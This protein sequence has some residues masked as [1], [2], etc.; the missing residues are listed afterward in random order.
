MT[1]QES[2]MLED[3]VRKVEETELTEKDPEAEQLLQEGLG[4]DPDAIYKLAQTVL[5][6][7]LALNQARTQIQQMQ[8]TQQQAQPARATSFLGG[9]LGH[10]DPAPPAPQP[11]YQQVPYQQAPAYQAPP[12]YATAPPYAA[13]GP[14][15]AGSFLRSAATTA[16]GVAAGALAFEGIESLM[17]GF[18]H[19]GG[20]SWGGGFGSGAP[21]VEETVVNN[22]YDDPQRA[23]GLGEHSEHEASFS[24]R[25]EGHEGRA[26][27]EDA[28]YQPDTDSSSF[29]DSPT[30]DFD[31][32]L[33]GDDFGDNG[34][35]SNFA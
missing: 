10:R 18:G 1:P 23:G 24:D 29:D 30:D 4:R 5:V 11:Q 20:G 14:S 27:L 34:D 28:S 31:S 17:H 15:P 22:Y 2:S 13:P 8:Q 25:P 12:Q 16:A 19:G 3:L 32:N 9:L 26:V 6:Q 33:G 21:P 7:N 35:D